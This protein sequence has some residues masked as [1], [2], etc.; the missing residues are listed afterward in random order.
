MNAEGELRG[1]SCPR[2]A[3]GSLEVFLRVLFQIYVC[4]EAEAM[5]EHVPPQA[6]F[7]N[8]Q[9][10]RKTHTHTKWYICK[11]W[12]WCVRCQFCFIYLGLLS[13]VMEHLPS[14]PHSII[15]IQSDGDYFLQKEYRWLCTWSLSPAS[16]NVYMQEESSFKVFPIL[17]FPRV[18]KNHR[19]WMQCNI[20]FL[21]IK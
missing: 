20:F 1:Q 17:K 15:L 2:K 3:A 11:I 21:L 5:S 8:K 4:F 18:F 13:T 19:K 7:T 6:L 14:L 10:D 9:A 16:H 12:L